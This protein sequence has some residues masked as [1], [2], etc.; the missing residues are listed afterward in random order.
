MAKPLRLLNLLLGLLALAL[1]GALADSMF[2]LRLLFQPRA[3]TLERRTSTSD[4][5]ASSAA[6]EAEVS[7]PQLKASL[8][9][10]AEFD[11]IL[12]KDPFK[13]PFPAPTGPQPAAKPAP[14][15]PLPN[16]LGTIFVGDERR[17]I[18]KVGT[19]SDVYA[20]GQEVAGG[21]LVEI[22][23]D[24]VL[25]KREGGV[26][27]VIFMAAIEDVSAPR[28]PGQAP[29]GPAGVRPQPVPRVQPSPPPQASGSGAGQLQQI[30]QRAPGAGEEP[31]PELERR[32]RPSRRS[33]QPEAAPSEESQATGQSPGA[34]PSPPEQE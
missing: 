3:V 8:P 6:S 21:T 25:F 18:L 14:Q 26:A 22:K 12:S 33:V 2:N 9:P 34:S 1:L 30:F 20:V 5:R 11:V 4:G 13:N 17:A 32:R 29:T 10:L 28:Q 23:E 16:L 7:P 15:V 24:R 31:R 27:E 19:R